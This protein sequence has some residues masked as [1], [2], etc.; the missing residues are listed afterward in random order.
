M[1][2]SIEQT[3]DTM[4]NDFRERIIYETKTEIFRDL[5]EKME[6]LEN[7]ENTSKDIA[8]C[9]MKTYVSVSHNR[10][11]KELTRII[12]RDSNNNEVNTDE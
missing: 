10:A 9:S 1:G 2:K 11:D 3:L 8:W 12:S 4:L 5:K 7:L 6:A